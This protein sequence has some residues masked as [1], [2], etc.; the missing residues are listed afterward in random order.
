MNEVSNEF[1][2]KLFAAAAKRIMANHQLDELT[3]KLRDPNVVV[4]YQ[5][6]QTALGN[7]RKAEAHMLEFL[8]PDAIIEMVYELRMSRE[9]K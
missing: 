4:S 7:D 2:N 5:E 1:L 9:E 6:Y 3:S 8:T